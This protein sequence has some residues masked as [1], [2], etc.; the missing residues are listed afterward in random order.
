MWNILTNPAKTLLGSAG[1]SPYRK[2]QLQYMDNSFG[3]G[4]PAYGDAFSRSNTDLGLFRPEYQK[5]FNDYK[6]Y[7]SRDPYASGIGAVLRAQYNK[8]IRDQDLAAQ[9]ALGNSQQ[10]SGIGGPMAVAQRAALSIGSA[11]AR[12]LADN[13]YL[14]SRISADQQRR[15]TLFNLLSGENTRLQGERDSGFRNLTAASAPYIS[16]WEQRAQQDE[17]NRAAG[18]N[19]VMGL[20][21]Q[22]GS[23][24]TGKLFPSNFDR[25]L[26][27]LGG[28]GGNDSGELAPVPNPANG[29]PGLGTGEDWLGNGAVVRPVDPASYLRTSVPSYTDLGGVF[30]GPAPDRRGYEPP[31]DSMKFWSGNGATLSPL[32]N[33]FRKMSVNLRNPTIPAGDRRLLQMLYASPAVWR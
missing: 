10:R 32:L 31:A 16:Y 7:L 9:A 12:A 21:G 27:L 11:K 1:P 29:G 13:N 2:D 18:R 6:G 14:T 19:A 20:L 8:G 17:A 22:V 5:G 33:G 15:G 24:A 23:L 28:G 25:Y 3:K 30:P 26:K 4:I